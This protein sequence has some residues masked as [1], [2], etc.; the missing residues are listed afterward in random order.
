MK[1]RYVNNRIAQYGFHLAG[2]L[3]I[4]IL[5]GIFW[6]LAVNGLTIFREISF[7]DFCLNSSWNPAAYGR[8]S[9]GI[10]PLLV[11]T[12]MV[13]LGAMVIAVPIG[14]GT[15]AYLAEVAPIWIRELLK[16]VIEML[17]AVPSVVV[18]FIGIVV[19]NPLLIQFFGLSNGLNALNGSLLLSIMALPTIITVAEEAIHRVPTEYREGSYALGANSWETLVWVSLPSCY[20]GLMAAVVLGI[21]RAIGETMTVLMA[22]GNAIAMPDG[23]FSSVRTLTATIAIELGEVARGTIHYKALFAVGGV[24]FLLTGIINIL[25]ERMVARYRKSG[26]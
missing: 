26:T 19:I 17:A 3:S 5:G 7:T 20:S 6:M 9:Y 15:A 10:L 24:L 25:A 1:A 8:P 11:S 4:A 16:P 21:G 22:T 13:T 14:I 18:G 23:I 2:G 12:V